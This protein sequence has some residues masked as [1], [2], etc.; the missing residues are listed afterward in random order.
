V[1]PGLATLHALSLTMVGATDK[2]AL[3]AVV[4]GPCCAALDARAGWLLGGDEDP[5]WLRMGP[6]FL[7]NRATEPLAFG[8]AP[9]YVQALAVV[10]CPGQVEQLAFIYTSPRGFG[11][12]EQALLGTL[13][14]LTGQSLARMEGEAVERQ[15]AR[16]I[17]NTEAELRLLTDTVPALLARIDKAGTCRFANRACE[18]WFG[19]PRNQILGRHLRELLGESGYDS[20][21]PA[22]DLAQDGQPGTLE[23]AL[24]LANGQ[25]RFVHAEL[26]PH[27]N[28]VGEVNGFVL[29]VLDL[30]ERRRAEEALQRSEEQLRQSQKMDAIG[31]LA[32]G[33]A[34]DFNNLLTAINGYSEL[35]AASLPEDDSLQPHIGEIRRAGDRAA[36]LTRQ[37]L[38]FSRKQIPLPRPLLI[39]EVVSDMDRMLRRLIPA[40]IQFEAELGAGTSLVHADPG[41]IEQVV[42]NLVLNA[43][44]AVGE[45]GKIKVETRDIVVHESD[46]DTFLAAAPGDYVLLAVRD[47]G[48]G[49]T[50]ESRAHLFEPFFT[51]KERGKGTGLGLSTVYGI[52]KQ[53]QGALRVLSVPGQGTTFEVM[54]PRASGEKPRLRRASGTRPAAGGLETVLL[55]EDEPAVRTLV[56]RVLE[57]HGY[58]VLEA[59]TGSDA[60]TQLRAHSGKIDLLMTDLV[61]PGMDG[62]ELAERIAR[63]RPGLRV[64]FMSGYS[65]EAVLQPGESD[66]AAGFLCK[67]F[68]PRVVAQRVREILDAA[69]KA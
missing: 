16:D 23:R 2:A 37:L 10:P 20:L 36:S 26:L 55:V 63:E 62:R 25:L 12:N 32:G 18:T 53:S 61:M 66:V 8:D 29:L 46:G 33:I 57:G 31:R 28:D 39:N 34:H 64:L 19:M 59:A 58:T 21:R 30:T 48:R 17:R 45:R 54:L 6:R 24:T 43:R 67:P 9:A 7:G 56:A 40:S 44:D 60:L 3:G 51:T 38:T 42:L 5:A 41:Q 35:L 22:L 49:L 27:R 15:R 65:E 14:V 47:D 4:G 1:E 13:G 11:A 68:S 69:N 50:Q 52:V